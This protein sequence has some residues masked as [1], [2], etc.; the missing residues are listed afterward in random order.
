MIPTEEQLLALYILGHFFSV[1]V[2]TLG[3]NQFSNRG[4][5][6]LL[7]LLHDLSRIQVFTQHH[8]WLPGGHNYSYVLRLCLS[9]NTSQ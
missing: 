2:V 8:A 3:I 6:L 7:T 1:N 9:L 5:I 4:S